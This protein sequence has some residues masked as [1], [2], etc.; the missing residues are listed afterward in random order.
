MTPEKRT[1]R[2]Q[3]ERQVAEEFGIDEMEN[4]TEYAIAEMKKS[5][6]ISRIGNANLRA[7]LAERD[8]ILESKTLAIHHLRDEVSVRDEALTALRNRG[9][10]MI[11][12]A[13]YAGLDAKIDINAYAT[14]SGREQAFTAFLARKEKP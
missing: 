7:E 3:M 14:A 11:R 1:D 6:V 2:E 8:S 10:K 13:Y 12:E 5:L 4:G 9:E